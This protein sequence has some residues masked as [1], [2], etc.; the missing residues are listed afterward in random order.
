[1]SADI[2]RSSETHIGELISAKMA[3]R[4]KSIKEMAEAVGI[5]Y[6]HVRRVVRGEAVP[7]KFVLKALC[8]ALG[9]PYRDA[10]RTATADT[11]RFKYGDFPAEIAGKDPT[12]DPIERVWAQLTEDQ[13]ATLID[14][15]RSFVKRN[16]AGK[17]A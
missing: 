2:E 4:G 16:R 11:I 1:M 6:E 10:Q 12:L 17:Q 15:A 3:E 14:M 9:I 8:D 7:S 13:K 5:T